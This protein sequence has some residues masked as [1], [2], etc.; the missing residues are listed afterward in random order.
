M[1]RSLRSQS[2]VCSSCMR[3]CTYLTSTGALRRRCSGVA[4]KNLSTNPLHKLIEINEFLAPLHRP[5]K[6]V[7]QRRCSPGG[8]GGVGGAC[9]SSSGYTRTARRI[10]IANC[11]KKEVHQASP[12]ASHPKDALGH[13]LKSSLRGDGGPGSTTDSIDSVS[14]CQQ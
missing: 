12:A 3:A 8:R 13:P 4:H 9:G 1:S 2:V 6:G 11:F 10:Y 5:R 14:P 7:P